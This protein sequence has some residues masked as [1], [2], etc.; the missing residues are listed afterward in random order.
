MDIRATPVPG[1]SHTNDS[2]TRLLQVPNGTTYESR[3]TTPEGAG[4]VQC[5][6]C[7]G[8]LGQHEYWDC[9]NAICNKCRKT[10]HT[11]RNCP[12]APLLKNGSWY[13]NL[14]ENKEYQCEYCLM[15]GHKRYQCKELSLDKANEYNGCGCDP[16][17]VNATRMNHLI[18]PNSLTSKSKKNHCCSCK[19]PFTRNNLIGIQRRNNRIRLECEECA[20]EYVRYFRQNEPQKKQVMEWLGHKGKLIECYLCKKKGTKREFANY[21]NIFF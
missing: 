20:Y 21:G 3:T 19:I 14:N 16:K 10:G 1:N 6:I 7:S 8:T 5:K 2:S 12:H 11:H 18:N 17:E 4:S 15:K 13:D 9:P